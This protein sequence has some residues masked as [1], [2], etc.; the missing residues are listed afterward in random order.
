[1]IM[2]INNR[3]FQ[4]ESKPYDCFSDLITVYELF[5]DGTFAFISK[6]ITNDVGHAINNMINGG[7]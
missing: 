4:I 2:T 5:N 3:K 1:M 6:A 7:K